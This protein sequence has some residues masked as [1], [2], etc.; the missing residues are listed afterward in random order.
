[1]CTLPAPD[2]RAPSSRLPRFSS[3]T[4][5]TTVWCTPCAACPWRAGCLKPSATGTGT[6]S[7]TSGRSHRRRTSDDPAPRA[8]AVRPRPQRDRRVR[9]SPLGTEARLLAVH[10]GSPERRRCRGRRRRVRPALRRHRRDVRHV[11]LRRLPRLRARPLQATGTPTGDT[12]SFADPRPIRF[13]TSRRDRATPTCSCSNSTV[14]STGGRVSDTPNH[15]PST[16]FPRLARLGSGGASRK[17]GTGIRRCRTRG[18]SVGRASRSGRGSRAAYPGP[19]PSAPA[20]RRSAPPT[21]WARSPLGSGPSSC[22][23]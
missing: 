21:R 19:P 10:P 11:Q 3:T 9:A 15:S 17:A 7:S 20:P 5:T 1:M 23:R 14:P 2:S 6:V 16:P 13:R 4:S 22:S 18:R 8:H 12:A